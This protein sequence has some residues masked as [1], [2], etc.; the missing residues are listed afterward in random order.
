LRYQ[1]RFANTLLILDFYCTIVIGS[2]PEFT[3]ITARDRAP[4]LHVSHTLD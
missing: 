1:H 4:G 2:Q 3:G